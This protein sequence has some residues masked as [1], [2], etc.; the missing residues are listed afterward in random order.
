LCERIIG[1]DVSANQIAH[2]IPKDNIEY[3]C[4]TGEDLS[5][6]QSN[7][8]DLITIATT[9]HWLDVE[10]FFEEAKRILKSDTGVLAIWTYTFGTL[11]NP[12][13]EAIY[14]EFHHVFLFPYWNSKQHLVDDY[15][16]SLVPLFP[17]ESTLRQYTIER[18]SETTL[19]DFLGL[20]ESGSAC[21]TYRKQNGEE[22][23]KNTLNTLR[24]KLSKCYIKTEGGNNNDETKDSN[25]IKITVSNPIRLYLMK[26]NHV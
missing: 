6:L 16:Q 2:A 25:S 22:E 8:V 14:H 20:I 13:A 21:Q 9:F 1:I 7:S 12:L 10:V 18:Q 4:N 11:D 3:R 19:G 5:F 26:K 17:Y 24:D 23:Y 15:Y